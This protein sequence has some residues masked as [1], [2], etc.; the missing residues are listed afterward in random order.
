M[1]IK[2][3]LIL[4]L[5]LILGCWFSGCATLEAPSKVAIAENR[6]RNGGVR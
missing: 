1:K 5:I 6:S 4:F 3:F 2:P